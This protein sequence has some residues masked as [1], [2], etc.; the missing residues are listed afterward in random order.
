M[1]F[2][3]ASFG[4]AV[5]MMFS[6]CLSIRLEHARNRKKIENQCFK[7]CSSESVKCTCKDK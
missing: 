1:T 4:T 6:F 3:L 7:I 2:Y 5:L